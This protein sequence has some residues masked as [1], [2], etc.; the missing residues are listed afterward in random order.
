MPIEGTPFIDS[1]E[2]AALSSVGWA[3]AAEMLDRLGRGE[4]IDLTDS[5][6]PE[7]VAN[8][9]ILVLVAEGCRK[10]AG[11]LDGDVRPGWVLDDA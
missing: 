5:E 3:R 6:D 7:V 9:I 2:M 10:M 1:G 4:A 8:R 11:V